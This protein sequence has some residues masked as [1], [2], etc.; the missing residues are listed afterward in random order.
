MT[1]LLRTCKSCKSCKSIRV[2][3]VHG[4]MVVNW[5]VGI[6]ERQGPNEQSGLLLVE[7]KQYDRDL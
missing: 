6:G 7:A 2:A 3:A 1:V 5:L 4:G